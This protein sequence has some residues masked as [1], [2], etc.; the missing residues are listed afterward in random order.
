[1]TTVLSEFRVMTKAVFVLIAA[2]LVSPSMQAGSYLDTGH[3]GA[4]TQIDT[5][6]TSVWVITPTSNATL[7]GGYFTMKD[8]SA[9][10]DD[11]VLTVYDPSNSVVDSVTLT[12]SQ[13]CQ[14][15]ALC[16]QFQYH[17]FLFAQPVSLN[18]GVTYRVELTSVAPN[19]QSAAYFIKGG[20]TTQSPS[21]QIALV[22]TL[23][24]VPPDIIKSFASA[25]T[26]LNVAT[27][28]TLDISNLNPS[29]LTGVSVSDSLPSGMAFGNPLNLSNTCG[30]TAAASNGVLSLTGASL[31]AGAVCQVSVD[32]KV[33]SSGVKTNTT[34]TITSIESGNG[35]TA[36]ASITGVAA[37]TLTKSFSQNS[38]IPQSPVT[39]T[40]TVANPN[41]GISLTGVN[42][43]DTLPNGMI[44]YN[45]ANLTNTCGGTASAANGQVTL[46]G[47]TLAAS[48]TCSVTVR[49]TLNSANSVTNTA[50]VSS[51]NGGAG[52]AASAQLTG[53]VGTPTLT[54]WGAI[55][56]C[57]LLS[58]L[59]VRQFSRVNS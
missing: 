9:T 22:G 31:G 3:T 14:G 2:M 42:F 36:S 25:T 37:P 23:S 39:M 48:Q 49:V 15:Y 30:G 5:A 35:A 38:V 26:P 44:L 59:S 41:S 33:T 18:G 20:G 56:L 32:I 53:I 27:V 10:I 54:G 16:G 55:L 34:G 13:F 6:H 58:F 43:S 12:H 28:L 52:T 51:T 45:P 29:A 21:T 7:D 1:M 46:S 4:Q 8:G 47:V 40:L 19:T 57:G 50:T 11:I 17:T 24:I